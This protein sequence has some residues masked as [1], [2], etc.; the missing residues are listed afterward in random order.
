[1][2]VRLEWYSYNLSNEAPASAAMGASENGDVIEGHINEDKMAEADQAKQEAN[3][4]FKGIAP[5]MRSVSRP[6]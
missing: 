4:A 5:L 2:R 1:M 3:D 6:G